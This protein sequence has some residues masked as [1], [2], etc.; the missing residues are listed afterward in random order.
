MVTLP[1]LSWDDP[2][3]VQFHKDWIFAIKLAL[4][5]E[6]VRVPRF[7]LKDST[8]L[9]AWLGISVDGSDLASC[10]RL[11]LRYDTASGV[12]VSYVMGSTKLAPKGHNVTPKSE[13][14]SILQGLRLADTQ[15]KTTYHE[16]QCGAIL[17]FNSVQ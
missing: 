3:P 15:I 14:S 1:D 7:C 17:C 5:C 10:A 8:K 11:F 4:E 2:I 9:E 13:V 12:K 6:K 16:I